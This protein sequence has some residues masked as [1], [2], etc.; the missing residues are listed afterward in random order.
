MSAL[1]PGCFRS[2]PGQISTQTPQPVQSPP[3]TATR[4]VYSPDVDLKFANDSPHHLLIETYINQN[5]STLVFKFYSTGKGQTVELEGPVVM[6]VIEHGDPVY[7]E[8]AELEPGEIKQIE[9]ATNGLTSVITRVIRDAATG[10]VIERQEFKS[11]FRPWDAVYLVGPGTE[12]PG[13][14]VIRLDEQESTS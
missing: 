4:H 5:T 12:V 1:R 6:D 9:W 8:D 13:H 3:E 10:D 7:R 14:D 2:L 11:K